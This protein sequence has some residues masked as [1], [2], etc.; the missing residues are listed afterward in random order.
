MLRSAKSGL[1]RDSI[2]AIPPR[3][4]AFGSS[5]FAQ[6]VVL[7][8]ALLIDVGSEANSLNLRSRFGPQKAQMLSILLK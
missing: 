7:V 4:E 6:V 5:G 1:R 2:W 3:P 8:G